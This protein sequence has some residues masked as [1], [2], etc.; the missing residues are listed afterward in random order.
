LLGERLTSDIERNFFVCLLGSINAI[1][2][3]LVLPAV[4]IE[5]GDRIA[6][7]NTNNCARNLR[8]SRRSGQTRRRR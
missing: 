1:Q 7:G 2:A 6:V 4:G 3:D 5:N 8:N